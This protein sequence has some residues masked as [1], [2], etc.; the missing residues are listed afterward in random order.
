MPQSG[1]H[2]IRRLPPPAVINARIRARIKHNLTPLAR[3]HAAY[4]Q[5]LV[6]GWSAAHRPRFKGVVNIDKETITLAIII[7]NGLVRVRGSRVT[8]GTLWLWW[9]KTGTRRHFIRGAPLAFEMGGQMVFTYVVDHP[10][11]TPKRKTPR[12]NKRLSG[13]VGSLLMLSVKEGMK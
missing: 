2:V 11:T 12:L 13:Q 7:V 3:K 6:A 8:I 4:R 5:V 1:M 9:E 10:G